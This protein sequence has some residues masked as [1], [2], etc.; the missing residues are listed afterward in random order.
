MQKVLQPHRAV[1]D[2]DKVEQSF[3]RAFEQ[4]MSTATRQWWLMYYKQRTAQ[5]AAHYKM[6]EDELVTEWLKW[7]TE[8]RL[9]A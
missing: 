8:L 7:R 4:P 5:I 2:Y 6:D 9:Q 3:T 1:L